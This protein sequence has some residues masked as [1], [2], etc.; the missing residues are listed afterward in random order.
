[1]SQVLFCFQ[2]YNTCFR[3]ETFSVRSGQVLVNLVRMF[4]AHKEKS[5]VSPF[6]KVSVDHRSDNLESGK[7]YCFGNVWKES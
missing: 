6:F 7:S 4:A 5:F 2:S 3:S 1:M